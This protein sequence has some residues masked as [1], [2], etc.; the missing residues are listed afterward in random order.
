MSSLRS[1]RGQGEIALGGEKILDQS[2]GWREEDGVTGFHQAMT[3]GAQRVGLAGTGQTE[4]QHVDAVFH[5][6]P[7]GQLVHLLSERQG[8]P[9][10]FEGFPGLARGEFGPLTQP[11]DAPVATILSFLLQDFE[12]GDQRVAMA[13]VGETGHRLGAHGGQLEL[14]AQLADAV[15]H[16]VGVGGHHPHT[17]AAV[18]LPVSRRS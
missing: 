14:V 8:H 5:E 15:L 4:G 10:V 11:V 1:C 18:M 16:D 12:E 17:P 6:A 7:L 13:S 3:Q 2:V 9:V